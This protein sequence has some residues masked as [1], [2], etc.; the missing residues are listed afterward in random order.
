MKKNL[1]NNDYEIN[2]EKD[3]YMLLAEIKR[4]EYMYTSTKSYCYLEKLIILDEN[5]KRYREISF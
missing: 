1:T 5:E 4:C 2:I 3:Y